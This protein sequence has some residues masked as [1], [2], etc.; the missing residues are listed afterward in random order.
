MKNIY[1]LYSFSK[2]DILKKKQRDLGPISDG[3]F[4]IVYKS[5]IVDKF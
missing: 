5:G 2:V 4:L 1:L 3:F